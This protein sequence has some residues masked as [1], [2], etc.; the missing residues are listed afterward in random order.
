MP[1]QIVL[2]KIRRIIL[3]NGIISYLLYSLQSKKTNR[4]SG[5]SKE[6][7]SLTLS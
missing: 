3:M 7:T 1:Y 5:L 6:V 2:Q 4:F